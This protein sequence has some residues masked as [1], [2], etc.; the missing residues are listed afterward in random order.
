MFDDPGVLSALMP[1]QWLWLDPVYHQVRWSLCA[2]EVCF[3]N[4]LLRCVGETARLQSRLEEQPLC[5][6]PVAAALPGSLLFLSVWIQVCG[7]FSRG[8]P[9]GTY[10]FRTPRRFST[11]AALPCLARAGSSSST[12]RRCPWSAGKVSCSP[13]NKET[14]RS[15]LSPASPSLFPSAVL[16]PAQPSPYR[17]PCLLS[18]RGCLPPHSKHTLLPILPWPLQQAFTSPSCPW[19]RRRW[20]RARGCTCSPRARSTTT[21]G[22]RFLEACEIACD[23]FRGLSS[24]GL[25]AAHTAQRLEKPPGGSASAPAERCAGCR[26]KHVLVAPARCKARV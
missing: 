5:V 12:A 3:K 26:V 20:A 6:E 9:R 22:E 2:R 10:A 8:W 13:S 24:R 11:L 15:G 19:R 4:E 16:S 17:A 25:F 23:L 1:W 14:P 7:R 18:S 21:A